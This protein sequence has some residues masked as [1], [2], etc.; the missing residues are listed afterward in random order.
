MMFQSGAPVT[1]SLYSDVTCLKREGPALEMHIPSISI[2]NLSVEVSFGS[3]SLQ[4]EA[5]QRLFYPFYG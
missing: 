5:N 3:I 1:L 2:W 4:F